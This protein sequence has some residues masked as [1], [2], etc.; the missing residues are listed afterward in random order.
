M[1]RVCYFF[2]DSDA[3][4]YE[5]KQEGML[6]YDGNYY[7]PNKW[8]P[9]EPYLI[10]TS[11]DQMIMMY[12]ADDMAVCD[13]GVFK[14]SYVDQAAFKANGT[15][16]YLDP[17]NLKPG[18]VINATKQAKGS[19]IVVEEGTTI[20]TLEGPRTVKAGKVV[21]IDAQGNPYVSPASN[22]VKRNTDFSNEGLAALD[23]IINE[24]A[25]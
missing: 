14:T 17:A 25:K 12:G 7:I 5:E 24:Q 10:N 15:Q 2:A 9:D 8:S 11:K 16:N 13:G 18:E 21:S 22:I 23:K 20:Q 3:G 19:F 1:V 6:G 4:I